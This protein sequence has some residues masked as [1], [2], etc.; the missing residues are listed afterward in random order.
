[1]Q[2]K[3]GSNTDTAPTGISG[4]KRTSLR[5]KRRAAIPSISRK[6]EMQ[7]IHHIVASPRAT[8]MTYARKKFGKGACNSQEKNENPKKL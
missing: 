3:K 8:L 2:K 6:N 5:V 4:R 7:H 1:L